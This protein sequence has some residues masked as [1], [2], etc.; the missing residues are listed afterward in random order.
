MNG[1]DEIVLAINQKA[2][3]EGEA[4]KKRARKQAGQIAEEEAENARLQGE[5]I[6]SETDR[7][8][9]QIIE[10]ARSAALS[11]KAKEL[12]KY[13][14]DTVR[15][16]IDGI[17]GYINSLPD[18]DYFEILKSLILSNY[19]KNKKGV[20]RFNERDTARL[21]RGFMEEINAAVGKEGAALSLGDVADIKDGFIL[22]YGDIEENCGFDAIISSKEDALKD[23]IAAIL[24]AD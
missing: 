20:I 9:A 23:E 8:C 14:A 21:P 22:V 4:I 12:L 1:L 11:N 18:K 7:K 15:G 17:A 16:I 24:F 10:S 19:H 6:L 13:K 3:L 2:K 5:K